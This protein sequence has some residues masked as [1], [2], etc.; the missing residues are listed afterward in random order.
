MTHDD[1]LV[2]KIYDNLLKLAEQDKIIA[3]QMIKMVDLIK[4]LKD[5]LEAIEKGG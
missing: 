1:V 5:R 2:Q 4:A 3:N